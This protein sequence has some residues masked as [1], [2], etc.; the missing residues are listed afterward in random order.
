LN[1]FI[2]PLEKA[3]AGHYWS[4]KTDKNFKNELLKMFFRCQKCQQKNLLTNSEKER[5]YL[6]NVGHIF[7]SL[8]FMCV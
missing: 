2:L 6:L 8:L 3:F 1:Y 5:G 7:S 4:S